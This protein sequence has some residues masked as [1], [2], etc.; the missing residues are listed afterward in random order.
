MDTVALERSEDTCIR[1]IR[2]R[3]H[4][5]HTRFTTYT[6]YRVHSLPYTVYHTQFTR[7]K[8]LSRL[9]RRLEDRLLL[10]A[11]ADIAAIPRLGLRTDGAV[12]LHMW[13]RV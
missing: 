2:R 13:T 10:T 11:Q 7:H 1:H 6:V 5:N 9:E 8:R 3:L 12:A 4:N